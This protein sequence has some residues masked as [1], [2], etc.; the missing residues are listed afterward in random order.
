MFFLK[1]E[2]FNAV[3]AYVE[4]M[5]TGSSGALLVGWYEYLQ[6]R[7]GERTNLYWPGIVIRVAFGDADPRKL[8][9][10]DEATAI[11]YLF[12]LLDEFLAEVRGPWEIRRLFQEFT[13][14]GRDLPDRVEDDLVRFKNYPPTELVS[15]DEAA[16]LLGLKRSEV[17]DR[18]AS[19]ALHDARVGKD[20][21]VRRSDVATAASDR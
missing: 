21:F 9:G 5:N 6:L 12:D 15:V 13:L 11:E 18:I 8:E 1:P 14:W 17:F 16:A 19:G 10:Q 2:S 20:V 3:A 7:L 4:G